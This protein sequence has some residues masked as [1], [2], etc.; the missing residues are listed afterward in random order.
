MLIAG[1]SGNRG[2]AS[3]L[4]PVDDH[5]IS[6]GPTASELTSIAASILSECCLLFLC[7]WRRWRELANLNTGS[8]T[9]GYK[10]PLGEPR[11]SDL[12]LP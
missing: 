4:T 2:T 3:S 7:C 11:R 10:W 9:I 6:C 12:Y 5:Q 1:S 8:S